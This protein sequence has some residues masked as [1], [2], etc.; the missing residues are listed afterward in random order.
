MW[1]L[2]TSKLEKCKHNWL[3]VGSVVVAALQELDSVGLDQIDTA[4][5]LGDAP[6]PD[7]GAEVFQRFGLADA[8]EGVAQNGLNQIQQSLCG[9][10]VRINPVL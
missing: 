3:E 10:A 4:M 6:G 9:S 2:Q 1:V 8:V 5:F 7:I